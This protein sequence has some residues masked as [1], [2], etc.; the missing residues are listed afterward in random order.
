MSDRIKE[1][2]DKYLAS[3]EQILLA[4]GFEDAFIGIGRRFGK[5]VAVYDRLKCVE[6]IAKEMPQE[7]ADEYFSFNVEGAFVGEQT[8]IFMESGDTVH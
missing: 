2:I 1:A 4:D 3:D 5:P 8:P 6:Q 7:D